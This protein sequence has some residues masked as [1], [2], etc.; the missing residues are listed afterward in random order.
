MEL[1]T[2]VVDVG[3]EVVVGA[4]DVETLRVVGGERH[5]T[6]RISLRFMKVSSLSETDK[7]FRL[8][9]PAS[10]GGPS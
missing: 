6:L 7:A 3:G 10:D 1:P 5:V 9:V 4:T 8:F 2:D